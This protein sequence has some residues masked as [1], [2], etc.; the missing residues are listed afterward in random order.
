MS[1][2]GRR[3][4]AGLA[5]AGGAWQ[6]GLESARTDRGIVADRSA[7][8][9]SGLMT[10]GILVGDRLPVSHGLAGAW[11]VGLESA[12]T[13]RGIV[14]DRSAISQSGFLNAGIL[15]GDRLRVSHGLAG[16]WQFGTRIGA[17]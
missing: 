15:V 6:V 12:R 8:S 9:Q 16:A 17:Y 5:R 1:D 10:A 2:F 14:A 13:D 11:Q 3:P 7:I 4:P